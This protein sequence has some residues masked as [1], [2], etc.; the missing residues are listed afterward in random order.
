MH[1]GHIRSTIIGDALA[2]LLRFKGHKVTTDNHIGDW[3]TAFGKIIVGWKSELDRGELASRSDWRNG[4]A[5]S[6]RER[7]R[8][9]RREH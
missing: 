5:L 8:Q 6:K 4:A 9:S 1:V 7:A 3:G 2:R